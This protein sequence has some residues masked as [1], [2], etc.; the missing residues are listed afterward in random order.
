MAQK[1]ERMASIRKRNGKWHVQ[2]RRANCKSITKTFTL[3]KYAER[4]ARDMEQK[5]DR[6]GLQIDHKEATLRDLVDRYLTEVSPLKK[7]YEIEKVVL[8]IFLGKNLLISQSI[9][10]PLNTL[11]S[12][13]ISVYR[14]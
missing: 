7:S 8:K 9:G 10:L 13:V 5:L 1:E 6:Q 3:K 2:V 11:P 4:W 12:S 14:K